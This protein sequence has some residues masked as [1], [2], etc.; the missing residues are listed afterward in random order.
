MRVFIA[1]LLALFLAGCGTSP[2]VPDHTYFQMGKPQALP[3]SE[4]PVFNTPIVVSL[5]AADGLYADRALIYA[6]NPEASELRQYHYQLWT[7]PPTRS[8]QRRLLIELRDAAIAPL[9]TDELAAS[10]AAVRIS[11]NILRFE[12]VPTVDGGFI[13]SVAV[14]LRVDRPDGTPQFD[15]IYNA[16]EPTSDK[17]LGSTVSA[18]S[19]AVDRIIAEFHADLLKNE[20]YE[21]AR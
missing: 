20:A 6:L 2:G 19:I 11:G 1:A 7:D 14:R 3:V 4:S 12:R 5:L 16:E 8:L 10:Q 17:L 15:E 9:V 18:I 13:A 21:H